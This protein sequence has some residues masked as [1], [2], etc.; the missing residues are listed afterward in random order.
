MPSYPLIA[1]ATS[2]PALIP[3]PPN[4]LLIPR[5]ILLMHLGTSQIP[6]P[7][8]ARSPP[9]TKP[10]RN[11]IQFETIPRQRLHRISSKILQLVHPALKPS[12]IIACIETLG[13][14]F[15]EP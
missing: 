12:Q 14:V 2:A 7:H 1:S 15:Q 6:Q 3:S 5:K 13:R 4:A 9:T 10:N 8:S 11:E